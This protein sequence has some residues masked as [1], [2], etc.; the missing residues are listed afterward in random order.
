M[1]EP[2][3]EAAT[4]K[5]RNEQLK[6]RNEKLKARNE[7]LKARVSSL[8]HELHSIKNSRTWRVFNLY[9]RLR[10]KPT[11]SEKPETAAVEP[12]KSVG[13]S[14]PDGQKALDALDKTPRES[15][16]A[17]REA[18]SQPGSLSFRCNICGQ[19]S[20]A[21]LEELYREVPSCVGCGSNVR[22]RSIIHVLSMEL[23]GES[24]ELPNFPTRPDIVGIGMSDSHT[25]AI[26]LAHKLNYRNTYLHKEPKLDITSGDPA[27]EGTLD[28]V[29]SSEVFEH[30]APPV[31]VAFEN[32]RKLLKP[33]GVLIFTVPYG[34]G[35]KNIEHFP[36]LYDY[37]IVQRGSDYVVENV[38]KDGVVQVF[39]QLV[40]HGGQGAT[41]EMRLFSET[42]LIEAFK[43]AGLNNVKIYK[44][45]DFDHGIY[46][47][48]EWALPMA[49]RVS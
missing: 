18:L 36:E 14:E 41:L 35:D 3:T 6:A 49:V 45:P 8:E 5:A 42:P 38:T 12:T 30:V 1:S 32:V 4:L 27:L 2:M 28:F 13:P 7:K 43:A 15:T 44:A 48:K 47:V 25:Y 33:T 20:L 31:S 23:F 29:I 21:R 46:W 11:S 34:K 17:R 37:R 10:T 40:F 16:E 39:D 26:P 24:L 22:G 19:A 9:R